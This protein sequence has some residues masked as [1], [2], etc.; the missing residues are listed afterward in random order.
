MLTI[1]FLPFIFV[2]PSIMFRFVFFIDSFQVNR[3]ILKGQA[4]IRL[5][6][7][8]ETQLCLNIAAGWPGP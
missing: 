3:S 2:A 5:S 6:V 7:L 4:V 8:K 1:S